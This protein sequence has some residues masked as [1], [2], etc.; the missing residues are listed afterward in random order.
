MFQIVTEGSHDAH[1][2][3]DNSVSFLFTSMENDNGNNAIIYEKRFRAYSCSDDFKHAGD[4][5]K[6][7]L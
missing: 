3:N 2:C 7:R 5:D 1:T 4:G 6:S